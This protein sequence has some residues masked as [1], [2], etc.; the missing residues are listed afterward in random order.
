[1]KAEIIHV[2]KNWI[3]AYQNVK[4]SFR[5]TYVKAQQW[6]ESISFLIFSSIL[7]ELPPVQGVSWMLPHHKTWQNSHQWYS[8]SKQ[9]NS[10]LGWSSCDVGTRISSNLIKHY[11]W[12]ENYVKKFLLAGWTV[13]AILY[14]TTTSWHTLVTDEFSSNF[15]RVRKKTTA[16]TFQELTCRILK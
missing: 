11:R 13:V 14:N 2:T 16:K 4:F 8:R 7:R 1:M 9:Q 15:D 12:E 5:K 3:R 10:P 6:Q